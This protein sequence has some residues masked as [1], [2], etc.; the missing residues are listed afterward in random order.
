MKSSNLRKVV[1]T[2]LV[3]S[4]FAI[5]CGDGS[6]AKPDGSSKPA[7]SGAAASG[8]TKAAAPASGT[9]TTSAAV[10]ATPPASSGGSA[11]T[12]KFMPATCDEARLFVNAKSLMA[13]DLGKSLESVQDKIV[14]KLLDM[15]GPKAKEAGDKAK[16]QLDFLKEQGVE[17][18]KAFK[19]L[20]GC[21]NKNNK[22]IVAVSVDL[23][24][25][26]MSA[27]DL[28]VKLSEMGGDTLKREED[29][30]VTYLTNEKSKKVLGFVTPTVFLAADS[31]DDIKAVAKGGDGAAFGDAADH[32]IWVKGE[33][34]DQKFDIGI[35]AA[36]SD[37]DVKALIPPMSA[38]DTEE[39]KKDPAAYIKKGEAEIADAKKK[40]EATPFKMLTPALD[41][42]K[43]EADGD[44]IKITTKFPQAIL[45]EALKVVA[46]MDP[47]QLLGAF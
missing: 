33:K 22:N 7:A 11:E 15:G 39:F 45:G 9:P 35:K 12:L 13:G 3:V 26:K 32:A 47:K 38:K 42:L 1:S 17:P 44:R 25:A 37:F 4:A 30:G 46:D 43:L 10:G 40:V 24:G 20:A 36:G 19:E 41:N 28:V 27:P 18:G 29:G 14:P 8:S 5:G 6:S 21:M 16:K 34:G 23:T 31:K 2:C